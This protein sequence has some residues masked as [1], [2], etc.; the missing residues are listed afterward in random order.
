MLPS[1]GA[2][3]GRVWAKNIIVIPH[4][5]LSTFADITSYFYKNSIFFIVGHYSVFDTIATVA[6]IVNL[7]K[8]KI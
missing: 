3:T 1:A 6:V 7:F 5:A 2:A 8:K 4:D